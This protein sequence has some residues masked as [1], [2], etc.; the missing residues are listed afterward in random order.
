MEPA[1]NR[2]MFGRIAI[3]IIL[4]T[5]LIAILWLV[6]GDSGGVDYR[7]LNDG[8]WKTVQVGIPYIQFESPVSLEDKSRPPLGQEREMIRRSQTFVYEQGFDLRIVA[9]IVDYHPHVYIDPSAVV[10]SVKGFDKQFGASNITYEPMELII[11]TYKA[12]RVD[13]TFTIGADKYDFS[14]VNAEY[15]NNYRDLLVIVRADDPEAALV[16]NH[17]VATIQFEPQ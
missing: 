1:K 10:L 16:R 6:T 3:G 2:N 8:E 4:G 15:R 11:G 12:W 7:A 14:R 9:S 17:I 13:G 5:A